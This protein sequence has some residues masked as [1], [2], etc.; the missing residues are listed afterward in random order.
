MKE[1]NRRAFLTLTGAAVA[2][3]AL[4]ACDD[5]P[6]APPA[7]PAPPAPTTPKEAKVL[8]AINKYRA[9]AGVKETLTMDDG[10]KPAAELV[11][12]ITK[13]E[14]AFDDKAVGALYQAY[15]HYNGFYSPIG[16]HMDNDSLYATPVC[17]YS[18]NAEEMAQNLN[19]QLDEGDKASL[20]S[21][22]I[23]L[24]NIKT[25]ERNGVTYWIAVIADSK[26]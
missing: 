4:T 25:F 26:K 24:V 16:V 22:A 6:Y 15:T 21:P 19:N 10:L 5:E 11:V 20:S 1:L 13:G 18:D 7:P 8:E 3:M 9:A 2:M 14:M 23:K 17:V 12:K